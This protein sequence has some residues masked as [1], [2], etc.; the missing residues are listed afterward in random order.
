MSQ[1]STFK[2]HPE[3]WR[4]KN[5][6]Y[7]KDLE[8]FYSF[9]IESN[10]KVLEIGVGTGNLL[11]SVRPKVG[12]GIDINPD[13]IEVARCKYQHL[14]FVCGDAETFDFN[15]TFDYAIAANTLSY[16]QDVQ[17][18]IRNL[19]NACQ[20]STR[21]I[22]TFHNPLWEPILRFATAIGQRMPVPRLNWLNREDVENILCLEG[23]EIVSYG[24]R[25]IFPKYI[26]FISSFL[27]RVIAPLP[28]VNQLC[29]TEYIIA[30][31]QPKF[32]RCREKT[33]SVIVPA[34]N[35][36]G[37]IERCITEMPRLGSRTEI[38]FIEGHSKDS[39]WSE[40]QRVQTK[41][42]N[43]WDIK[44]RQQSGVGKG[45]AVRLGFSIASGDIF[46]ILDSDLTVAPSDLVYFFDSVANG[47]SEM[48]NGC[49]LVY[50]VPSKEMPMLNRIANRFFAA[51]LSYLL[52][53]RIKD[54][55]CGTKAISRSNYLRLAANRSYFGDFDPFGDFD[56]LFGSAKLGLNIQDIPVRYRPRTY[57]TSNIDHFR[58]GL[59]L[60]K[61]CLHAA[62]KIRFT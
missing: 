5:S 13:A 25:L 39:T 49:R 43:D 10:S 19:R 46:I 6:Y 61:M 33:C 62:K 37:N 53:V 14:D 28:I 2:F 24:K 58:E 60:L 21:L 48:A 42:A 20:P 9:I 52:N 50:P 1:K 4:H 26:P 59:L 38:V 23:F 17:A 18:T 30:R 45:D 36:A 34:R 51:L 22:L 12:L 11:N 40:I 27:N 47:K 44:I 54:S 29:L 32:D 3:K 35:E 15:D 7:Y 16:L 57:G 55:L 41:Y 31:L 8:K 56:M